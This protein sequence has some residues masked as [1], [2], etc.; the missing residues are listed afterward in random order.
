MADEKQEMTDDEFMEEQNRTI[1]RITAELAPTIMGLINK[2]VSKKKLHPRDV[3]TCINTALMG[4][5]IAHCKM[6]SLTTRET[7]L[8]DVGGLWDSVETAPT[9]VDLATGATKEKN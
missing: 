6:F 1:D 9:V 7:F 5:S 3:I 4:V 8:T 2:H